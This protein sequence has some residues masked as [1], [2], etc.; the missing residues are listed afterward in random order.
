MTVVQQLARIQVQ[1]YNTSFS[2]IG[3]LYEQPPG[4][5]KSRFYV[6][7]SAPPVQLERNRIDR[8]PWST[9]R[10]QLRAMIEEQIDEIQNNET[11]LW[12]IRRRRGVDNSA[13]NIEDCKLL[14]SALLHFVNK[15]KLFNIWEPSYS[16]S[17]PDLTRRNI[18]VGYND[19]TCIF[20]LVDWEGARIQPPVTTFKL[21]IHLELTHIVSGKPS[22][23]QICFGRKKIHPLIMTT[24]S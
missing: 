24:R 8:G 1:L 18:L 4:L 22:L 14:Y 19:P 17:H 20:A 13:F 11:T 3:S 5:H 16:L 2:K 9:S 12:S 15:A 6:G 7:R 23:P 21:H 10:E